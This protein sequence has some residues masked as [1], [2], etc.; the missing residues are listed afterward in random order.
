MAG[1]H[2]LAT[3][4]RQRL[5][6]LSDTHWRGMSWERATNSGWGT[7]ERLVKS[8][9][10]CTG[11]KHV[12]GGEIFPSRWRRDHLFPGKSSLT[13]KGWGSACLV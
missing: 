5:L 8:K 10:G 6:P 9:Q 7:K 13:P 2:R 1:I 12:S 11:S 3:K 4:E